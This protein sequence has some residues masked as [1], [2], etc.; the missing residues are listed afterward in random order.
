MRKFCGKAQFR[1]NRPKLCKNCAFPQNF[2]TRKLD[3]ITVLYAVKAM[4]NW[5]L[6]YHN[7]TEQNIVNSPN[8]LEWKFCQ[9][10]HRSCKGAGI[11]IL[12]L[13]LTPWHLYSALW[14]KFDNSYI[15]V[16]NYVYVLYIELNLF[17]FYLMLTY[18]I[19]N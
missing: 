7:T 16:C 11:L 12:I 15:L 8:F 17:I 4:S 10:R 14:F 13:I 2:H 3:D 6:S 19:Y 18:F 9:N 5:N 1:V